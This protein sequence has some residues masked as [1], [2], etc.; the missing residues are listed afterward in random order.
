MLRSGFH[1]SL[2]LLL[3][4][5]PAHAGIPGAA[6]Q[7]TSPGEEGLIIQTASK[8]ASSTARRALIRRP[9]A[10]RTIRA[11]SS[12][13]RP[14][15]ASRSRIRKSTSI[16]RKA[17]RRPRVKAPVKTKVRAKVR[18]PAATGGAMKPG[19][20]AVNTRLPARGGF[21]PAPG[22]PGGLGDK[23]R[24]PREDMGGPAGFGEKRD[25]AVANL[26]QRPGDSR[27]APG[28]A[29]GGAAGPGGAGE[30]S[31]PGGGNSGCEVCAVPGGSDGGNTGHEPTP[32]GG[33]AGGS[34]GSGGQGGGS[35]SQGM[36]LDAGSMGAIRGASPGG[37]TIRSGSG[38]GGGGG[39]ASGEEEAPEANRG[40]GSG[41]KVGRGAVDGVLN[42]DATGRPKT[43]GAGSGRFRPMPNTQPG[44]GQSLDVVPE[45]GDFRKKM[46][47]KANPFG[48]VIIKPGQGPRTPDPVTQPPAG[49]DGG[50]TMIRSTRKQ[51]PLE[52]R[53]QH[54]DPA[55]GTGGAMSQ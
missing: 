47:K 55:G 33:S 6:R 34:G 26:P 1:I 16:R 40:S 5:S 17:I 20:D 36:G 43:G 44:V 54:T 37:Q 22:Q 24:M 42:L 9:A 25:P 7:L 35:G 8:S 38:D 52:K 27:I 3:L 12:I 19:G 50:S 4:T 39:E 32:H 10:R 30:D 13:R 21:R 51:T 23:N 41:R 46:E 14:G 18:I 29:L 2:L 49:M 31:K 11:R 45:P 15:A 28:T 48:R 53:Q